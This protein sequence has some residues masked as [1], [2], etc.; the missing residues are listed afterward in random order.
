MPS[1]KRFV[2][3]DINLC[4]MRLKMRLTFSPPI[5]LSLICL[6]I[7]IQICNMYKYKSVLVRYVGV[8]VTCPQNHSKN[9]R[10][11]NLFEYVLP[12]IQVQICRS[13]QVHDKFYLNY[14]FFLRSRICFSHI[15][16]IIAAAIMFYFF[17]NANSNR[18]MLQTQ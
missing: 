13:P 9:T 7:R 18:R 4:V 5:S 12:F 17:P 2:S 6:S 10:S 8:K 15:Q 11:G 3:P 1:Q 14:M 16:V